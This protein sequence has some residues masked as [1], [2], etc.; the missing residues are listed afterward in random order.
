MPLTIFLLACSPETGVRSA[1]QVPPAED[2][3]VADD[4]SADPSPY[5]TDDTAAVA[6]PE[7][8]ADQVGAAIEASIEAILAMDP[9]DIADAYESIWALRDDGTCPYYYPEYLELYDQYIWYDTC[10]ATSGARFDGYGY[11][12]AYHGYVGSYYTYDRYFSLYGSPV[13][14]SLPNGETLTGSGSAYTYDIDYWAYG[15]RASTATIQGTWR[16][17][18]EAWADSWLGDGVSIDISFYGTQYLSGATYAQLNGSLADINEQITAVSF[19]DVYLMNAAAGTACASEPAG[20]IRIRDAVGGWYDATFSGP[21]YSGAPSFPAY[22]DGCVEV[23]WRGESLGET[24]PDTSAL[25]GWVG[26]PWN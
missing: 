13:N 21:A 20:T 19:E 17:D 5:V 7:L 2:P 10:T 18:G 14:M 22:C 3:A 1:E 24:C 25:V 6:A 16:W 8:T 23:W 15:F 11:Y 12:T 26:R 9:Y 4:S